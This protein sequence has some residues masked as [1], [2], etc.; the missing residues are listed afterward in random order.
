[1][2]NPDNSHFSE[3]AFDHRLPLED[4]KPVM[5]RAFGKV[6]IYGV[7]LIGGS[8]GLALRARQLA[9]SVHG[10]GRNPTRLEKAVELGAIDAYN[11][12]PE[13]FPQDLEILVLGTPLSVY[14]Q[15]LT[16][17]RDRLGSETIVTDV[18]SAQAAAAEDVDRNLPPGVAFVGAHP[19]AGGERSGCEA[20]QS[21][22]FEGAVCALCPS[23]RTT[24][25]SL[26]RIRHLWES[27]GSRTVIL[28]AV[29]HD[30]MVGWTSHLPHIVA[31]ALAKTVGEF[32]VSHS[33]AADFV[34]AGFRDTTRIASGD[35][36]M[37]RDVCR[38]NRENLLASLRRFR[39]RIDAYAEGLKSSDP[40][41]LFRMLSEAKQCRDA[42]IGNDSKED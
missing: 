22:L 39:D 27:V 42:L 25:E 2:R 13:G 38:H 37:W 34:G 18:G 1:M 41:T 7:G 12:G 16:G 14:A 4:E 30:R 35:A 32:A 8:L 20:A 9:R 23:R 33:Q 24:P 31:C 5:K 28:D 36:T 40:E 10:I 3:G 17:I 21:D 15:V 11:V 29:D 19:I 26:E 6:G